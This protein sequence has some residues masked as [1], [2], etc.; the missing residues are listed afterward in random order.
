MRHACRKD[1]QWLSIPNTD[2]SPPAERVLPPGRNWPRGRV[3][4]RAVG[5]FFDSLLGQGQKGQVRDGRGSWMLISLT[6]GTEKRT[7]T[8]FPWCAMTS[9]RSRTPPRDS[10]PRL[11]RAWDGLQKKTAP[12]NNG[13]WFQRFTKRWY[14]PPR[15]HRR[16]CSSSA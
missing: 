11:D 4:W 12:N 10:G 9:I 8:Y 3:W 2:P 7:A 1:N 13:W 5:C 6:G 15:P 14:P 16:C